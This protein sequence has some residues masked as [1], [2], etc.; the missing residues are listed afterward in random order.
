MDGRAVV[1]ME[2]VRFQR[3]WEGG[4]GGCKVGDS[5]DV[6]LCRW[7]CGRRRAGGGEVG[8]CGRM[9]RCSSRLLYVPGERREGRGGARLRRRGHSGAARTH[10]SREEPSHAL[11]S[12]AASSALPLSS[13]SALPA[14]S[15][16]S[17]RAQ[18][19]AKKIQTV[20]PSQAAGRARRVGG[21]YV[22]LNLGRLHDSCD[23]GR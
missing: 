8:R 18:E 5:F 4:G 7:V 13:L 16:R 20:A 21:G 10:G 12:P 17:Q 23:G 9:L 14:E 3:R 15:S 22:H 6:M 1:V 19:A 11:I 2:E